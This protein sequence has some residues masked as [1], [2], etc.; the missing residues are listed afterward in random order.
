MEM[1]RMRGIMMLAAAGIAIY[2]GWKIH[3]GPHAVLAY[4]LGALAIGLALW[5]LTRNASRP[6]R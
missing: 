2:K 4:G 6:R 3:F 1:N 5:H